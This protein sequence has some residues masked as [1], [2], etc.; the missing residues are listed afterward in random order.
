VPGADGRGNEV[1]RRSPDPTLR[2]QPP[3]PSQRRRRCTPAAAGTWM[4]G[5]TVRQFILVWLVFL[6]VLLLASARHGQ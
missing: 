6:A 3:A 5:L 2:R 1:H 4:L